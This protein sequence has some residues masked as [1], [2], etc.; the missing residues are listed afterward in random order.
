MGFPL[1]V[2]LFFPIVHSMAELRRNSSW[3]VAPWGVRVRSRHC[4]AAVNNPLLCV[5]HIGCPRNRYKG[6]PEDKM[7]KMCLLGPGAQVMMGPEQHVVHR[8]GL[9][10]SRGHAVSNPVVHPDRGTS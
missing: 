7:R 3:K 1:P 10:G 9:S 8:A 6:P 2:P 5:G 4:S